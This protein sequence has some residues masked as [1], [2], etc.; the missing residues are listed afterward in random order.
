MPRFSFLPREEKFF[1]LFK[2]STRNMVE[3]CKLLKDMVDDFTDVDRKIKKISELES[4]GDNFTH[5][6]IAKINSTFVTPFDREDMAK[7]ADSIDDII[8]FVEASAVSMQ[9][10]RVGTPALSAIKLAD[11]ILRCAIEVEAAVT[12]LEKNYTMES[13]MIRCIEIRTLESEADL[14]FQT[15]MAELF[16]NPLNIAYI[17][18]WREILQLMED[19]TD[20]CQDVSN[21]GSV[22]I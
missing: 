11:I 20:R 12:Q 2:S 13:I 7:L 16:N 8:D 22:L 19:A 15:A 10:Y 5:E 4:I 9:L 18:K 6:I 21:V 3:I 1:V 17:I 14:I